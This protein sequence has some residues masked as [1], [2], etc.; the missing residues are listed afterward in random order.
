MSSIAAAAFAPAKIN[1]FLEV[2]GRRPDGYHLL[3]SLVVFA[4]VGDEVS[5]T[6]APAL[7]LEVEGPFAGALAGETDNLVLRAARALAAALGRAPDVAIRLVKRL[8]IASGIGGGSSDA[9]ATLRALVDFW[10]RSPGV[11][12]LAEIALAL[13]A[14]VPAC[15]AARPARMSGIGEAVAP[16]D[17]LPPLWLVLANPMRPVPTGAVFRHPALA[18]SSERPFDPPLRRSADLVRWLGDRRNDLEAPAVAVEP[19]VGEVLG[20]L[21]ALPGVALARMSGSGGTCFA[22]FDDERVAAE[23]ARIL[24]RERPGWWVVAAPV[25]GVP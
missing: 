9:A 22:L 5:V 4:G 12:R 7:S 17:M 16:L 18:F 21:R 19:S 11:A 24:G 8:P 2:T 1:L 13:G 23:A 3:D 15:L 14:D 10:G 6:A 20:T 25:L